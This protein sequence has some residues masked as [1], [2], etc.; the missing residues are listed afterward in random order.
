MFTNYSANSIKLRD[1]VRI[2][3]R[4]PASSTDSHHGLLHYLTV[5]KWK[6][7]DREIFEEEDEGIEDVCSE[8]V[9]LICD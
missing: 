6:S 2:L 9:V 7:S 5:P 1:A 4:R 3:Q 8:Y